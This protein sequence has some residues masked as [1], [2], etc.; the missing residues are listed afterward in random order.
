[1]AF[2]TLH[3][4]LT[5]SRQRRGARHRGAR[6]RDHRFADFVQLDRAEAFAHGLCAVARGQRR[7]A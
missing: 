4:Q 6:C 1:M 3:S 2:S 7:V 5:S